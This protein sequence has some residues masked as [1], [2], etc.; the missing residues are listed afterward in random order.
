MSYQNSVDPKRD[1]VQRTE[2]DSLGAYVLPRHARWGV[3]TARAIDNFPVTGTPIGKFPDLIKALVLV[4]QAAASANHQ[5]GYLSPEKAAMIEKACQE[6]TQNLPEYLPDFKVDVLQGGA[7]TSTNMNA[8]EVVANVGLMASGFEAGQYDSLHP[9]DD[10]NMSQSTN[11][12][13]PTA[14]KISV[15]FALRSLFSLSE[16]TGK[17]V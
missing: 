3:H 12:V 2:R 10:V 9:N 6:I 15:C 5:L 11:D 13:Y 16:T 7:G 17:C 1:K 8:N 4:K 14:V